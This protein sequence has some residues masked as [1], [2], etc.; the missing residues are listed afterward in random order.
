MPAKASW[1][2]F[3]LARKG[4]KTVFVMFLAC[5]WITYMLCKHCDYST[6]E[7]EDALAWFLRPECPVIFVNLYLISKPLFAWLRPRLG[8]IV[9]ESTGRLEENGAAETFKY[10]VVLHNLV[11][12]IFSAWIMIKSWPMI[13]E[14]AG[15]WWQN[16]RRFWDDGFGAWAIIFY[17]SKFYEFIDSWVLVLKGKQPSFLQVYH[18]AGVVYCMY[19]GA[20]SRANWLIN[21]VCLNSFIHT[22]MYFYYASTT[23]V[24]YDRRSPI[25]VT[26]TTAQI[27]QFQIG[28]TLASIFYFNPEAVYEQF[29]G[30][31]MI[32]V[33]AM[34]LIFLFSDMKSEKYKTG[35]KKNA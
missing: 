3:A 19:F 29:V 28:I 14:Y 33:Y 11:L 22:L 6:A 4:E 8:L 5:S 18:H 30:L 21:I 13:P 1:N 23:F 24:E 10:A 35:D 27:T 17:V 9:N 15:S 16:N 7:V 12:C 26:L 20:V 32:Q 31:V 25:K 34:G 2:P